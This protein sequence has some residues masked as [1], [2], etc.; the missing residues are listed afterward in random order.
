MS[1]WLWKNGKKILVEAERVT[2]LVRDSGYSFTDE[3]EKSTAPK[4]EYPLHEEKK[5]HWKKKG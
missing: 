5:T 2:R 1:T 3:K 4:K